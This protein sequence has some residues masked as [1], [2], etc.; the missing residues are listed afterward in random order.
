[1][2]RIQRPALRRV[3]FAL[4]FLSPL[5]FVGCATYRIVPGDAIALRSDLRVR[6]TSPRTLV[7]HSP[8]GDSLRIEN[9][10]ELRGRVVEH[11]GDMITIEASRVRVSYSRTQRRLASGAVVTIPVQLVEVHE[12][13][14]V[15][16]LF[17]LLGV[18]SLVGILIAAAAPDPAPPAPKNTQKY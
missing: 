16:T 2:D 3:F 9:V 7:V 8:R 15:R 17:L 18:V 4:L 11:F 10:T 13:R 1:M 14:P 5:A 6:F 12:N